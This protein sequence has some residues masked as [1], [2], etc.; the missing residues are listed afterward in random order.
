MEFLYTLIILTVA[1]G[2]GGAICHGGM[3]DAVRGALG[4]LL[5]A[6]MIL[7]FIGAVSRLPDIEISGDGFE[8]DGGLE[9]ITS[10]AFAKGVGDAIADEFSMKESPDVILRDFSPS[11]LLA[12][13]ITVVIPGSSPTVDFRRVRDFVEQNFTRVGG[14][15]VV[16]G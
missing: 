10:V 3:R 9:E 5:L 15:E 8:V 1:V 13:S 16:Y 4:V 12:G 2:V 11:E 7:P 14:C 6:S